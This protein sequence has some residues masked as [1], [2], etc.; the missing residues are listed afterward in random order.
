MKLCE[1]N[2]YMEKKSSFN[3]LIQICNFPYDMDVVK[4]RYGLRD[5][6][7]GNFMKLET[8]INIQFLFMF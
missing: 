5:P 4:S 2:P 7:L 8:N 3:I 1:N 6:I